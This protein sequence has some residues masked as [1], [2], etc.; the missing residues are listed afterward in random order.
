MPAVLR[1][2]DCRSVHAADA[3]GRQRVNP[4]RKERVSVA[5]VLSYW[6]IAFPFADDSATGAP[7]LLGGISRKNGEKTAG[8]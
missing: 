4:A 3:S 8:A 2:A 6:F 1:S 7:E 5:V